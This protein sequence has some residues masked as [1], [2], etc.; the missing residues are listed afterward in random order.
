M[1]QDMRGE[2]AQLI[3]K[4]LGRRYEIIERIGGGGMAIVYKARDGLLNRRVAVK[5]LR[6]QFADDEDFVR[7]FRHEAQA[8]ASL[9]HPNIVSVYDVGEEDGIYFI[10]MEHVD[11]QTL[12]ARITEAAPLSGQEVVS[13]ALQIGQALSHAHQNKIVH[14]DIK[15]H[16]IMIGKDGRVKVADFGIAR[17][18]STSTLTTTGSIVGSVHYFS[19]E[20]A[21]GGLI[22]EKSDIYSLGVV[23][24]EMLTAKVPFEG[25]SP[26]SVALK[27]VQ[28]QV[29]PPKEINPKAPEGLSRVVMKALRK[30]QS[31]RYQTV[32]E[33]LAELQRAAQGEKIPELP[34]DLAPTLVM[35]GPLLP[36]SKG[37]RLRPGAAR[38]TA[39]V[40]A[41]LLLIIGLRVVADWFNV[42]TVIVP[43]LVTYK[44]TDAESAL[45]NLGL[46]M[47]IVGDGE[48]NKDVPSGSISRQDPAPNEQVKEG[49]TVQVWLSLGPKLVKVPLLTGRTERDAEVR[50]QGANLV[51]GQKTTDYSDEV[52]EGYIISQSPNPDTELRE[53]SSVDIIV[54]QGPKPAAFSLPD[55]SGE[56]WQNVLVRMGQVKLYM[57]DLSTEM[58]DRPIGT[59]LRTV[60]MAGSA[61]RPG[62]Q[63]SLVVSR[64]G[65]KTVH[66][67]AYVFSAPID[68][69]QQQIKVLL[70]D[71]LGTR[72]IYEQL[73]D[74]GDSINIDVRWVGTTATLRTMANGKEIGTFPLK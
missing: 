51:I 17:A 70:I 12:K 3:G 71:A 2:G 20:Q 66:S 41:A 9:S 69:P 36:R 67:Y 68:A 23:L 59:V 30:T 56:S 33:F 52:Q 57:G 21:R 26:I 18:A 1:S 64:G 37:R 47:K 4:V 8:A 58:S 10:I 35:Q 15:P 74:A 28:E 72:A 11:G 50:L 34:P 55:Y 16:N 6:A 14:R 61:V 49:R 7:R 42:P 46:Q 25:E 54:S 63:V 60:P 43:S 39:I 22:D 32:G 62:D 44:P 38:A 13:I 31:E 40:L 45:G 29:V 27:H 65:Y 5:V 19:P 24:Y 73:H 53:G 48:Y